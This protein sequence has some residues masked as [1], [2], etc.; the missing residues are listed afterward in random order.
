MTNYQEKFFLFNQYLKDYTVKLLILLNK[1][2]YL[3]VN[4]F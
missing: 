2:T 1:S 4:I 3:T